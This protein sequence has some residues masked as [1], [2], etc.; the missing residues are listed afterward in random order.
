MHVFITGGTGLVGV[1]EEG[2]ALAA[3]GE[4]LVG[5]TRLRHRVGHSSC[6]G[7]PHRGRPLQ[8]DGPVGGYR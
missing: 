7:P 4:T 2:A 5:T 3:L 1:A 8:T 6:S